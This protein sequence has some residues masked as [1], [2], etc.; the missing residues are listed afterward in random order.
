MIRTFR[1]WRELSIVHAALIVAAALVMLILSLTPPVYLKSVFPVNF[2]VAMH[3]I[4][5]GILCILTG[6][7]LHSAGKA[8]Y[9]ALYAALFSAMYGFFIECVQFGV[10]YRSFEVGDI[11]IN[12]CAA[13]IAIIPCQAILRYVPLYK[14]QT[15]REGFTSR[16]M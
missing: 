15:A 4:A 8:R 11:L 10:W 2:G 1:Y 3:I 14:K 9:P 13:T 6:T 7:W 5:Y 12:C 16:S